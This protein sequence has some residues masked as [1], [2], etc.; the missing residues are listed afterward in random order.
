MAGT[1]GWFAT[2]ASLLILLILTAAWLSTRRW[3]PGTA[4][5]V[6]RKLGSLCYPI[7]LLQFL[8]GTVASSL[9]PSGAEIARFAAAA[10]T[11]LVLS[12]L[13]EAAVEPALAGIRSRLRRAPAP[14][15][16]AL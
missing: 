3:V 15:S 7:Y 1:G 8:G 10:G 16:K 9:L 12:V 5:R 4:L 2:R 14:G 11:T 13:L 6:D